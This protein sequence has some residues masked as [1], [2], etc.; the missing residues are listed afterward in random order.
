MNQENFEIGGREPDTDK[1]KNYIGPWT[2]VVKN[3][4]KSSI[5]SFVSIQ[6]TFQR[7]LIGS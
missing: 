7:L 1:E 3:D 6:C 5:G 4:F 2:P